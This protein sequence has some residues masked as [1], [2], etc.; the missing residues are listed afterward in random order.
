MRCG[1]T[2]VC[3]LGAAVS[4]L[5]LTPTNIYKSATPLGIVWQWMLVATDR[6]I[7]ALALEGSH[8]Q[9]KWVLQ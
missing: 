7:E 4:R 6:V 8:A 1:P 2:H 5:W 3:V 9:E